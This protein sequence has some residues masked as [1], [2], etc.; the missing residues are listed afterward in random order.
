ME[1]KSRVKSLIAENKI[2]EAL[3][4]FLGW[5]IERNDSQLQNSLINIQ[6]RFTRLKH[7]ENLGMIQFTDLVREQALITNS[8]LEILNQIK[9]NKSASGRGA[10]RPTYNS[11]KGKEVGNAK[12]EQQE[13]L[14]KKVKWTV[15][16]IAG[17]IFGTFISGELIGWQYI[18]PSIVGTTIA[19]YIVI[20][21]SKENL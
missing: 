1:I 6:A 8:I 15:G 12:V 20:V 10:I 4:V 16:G 14:I 3:E 17:S 11:G 13:L 9:E 19:V 18:N 21:W 2:Q 5:A 7:Q